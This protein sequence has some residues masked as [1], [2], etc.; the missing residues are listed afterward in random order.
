MHSTSLLK[1]LK[2]AR[3]FIPEK[4]HTSIHSPF[5]IFM[6]RTD[7]LRKVDHDRFTIAT[8]NEDVEFVEITVNESRLCKSDDQVHQLRV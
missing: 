2:R 7:H 8:A 6:R 3:R 4:F 1:Y 5:G